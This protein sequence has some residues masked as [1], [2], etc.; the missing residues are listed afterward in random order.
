MQGLVYGAV[1]SQLVVI[2]EQG[3]VKV[4]GSGLI[5]SHGECTQVVEGG[6]PTRRSAVAGDHVVELMDLYAAATIAARENQPRVGE[7]LMR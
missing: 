1:S 7:A 2:R 5:S 4:Y 3:A 6:S